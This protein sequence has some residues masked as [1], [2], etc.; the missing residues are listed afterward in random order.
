MGFEC[1]FIVNLQLLFHE[2]GVLQLILELFYFFGLSDFLLVFH[3]LQL[4]AFSFFCSKFP[5]NLLF[6]IPQGKLSPDA[7]G[8]TLV[9]L[10]PICKST[11]EETATS[12]ELFKLVQPG[13]E[14]SCKR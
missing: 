14:T 3:S 7:K 11:L 5:C 6:F 12:V 13:I 2:K 10:D 9:L 8:S 1:L 4:L